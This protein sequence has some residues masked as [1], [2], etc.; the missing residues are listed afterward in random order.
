LFVAFAL[1]R[2]RANLLP[3]RRR[4]LPLATGNFCR[5]GADFAWESIPLWKRKK[6]VEAGKL[7]EAV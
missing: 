5:T 4:F 1:A 3:R 7:V 2:K 6:L